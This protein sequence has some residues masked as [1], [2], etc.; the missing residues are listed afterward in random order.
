MSIRV[1]I[2]DDS[3]VVRKVL[4]DILTAAA[5]I[6]VIGSAQDPIFALAH[7]E[8]NWPDV[9][10]LDIEMPRMDGITFLKKIMLER[11]TPIVMCSTLTE[12]GSKASLDALRLGAIDVVAKPKSDVKTSLPESSRDLVNAIKVAAKANMAVLKPM[13]IARIS[14]TRNK[15]NAD[16]MLEKGQKLGVKKAGSLIAIGASTGGT[17]A[18][19]AV[20]AALPSNTLPILIVQ[21][22]PAQFTQAFAKRLNE[23]SRVEV[24]EAEDNDAL[25]P[26][27]VLIAPGGKHMMLQV[28]QFG[29]SVKIKDGP[30]VNRHKPS[31]DVLFRSVAKYAGADALGIIMT[32]MGDDGAVGIKEMRDVGAKTIAQN[33]ETCVVYGMPAVAVKLGGIDHV[34]ALSKIPQMIVQHRRV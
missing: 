20:L 9:I 27:L 28:T 1:F 15:F 33:E 3:A 23:V 22:M 11:P 19:A 2:I 13:P 25:L 34:L 32:G 18:L 6:E 26:G 30:P 12:K 21:H 29:A 5:G 7:M 14:P 10:T 31:V 17:Q 16:A 8:K 24:K 4:T